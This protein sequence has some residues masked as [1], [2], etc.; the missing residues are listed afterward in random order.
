[1]T[2]LRTIAALLLAGALAA[3]ETAGAT[4]QLAWDQAQVTAIAQE[5][6]KAAENLRSALRNEP[7]PTTG[8]VGGRRS[9]QRFT[10]IVRRFDREAKHLA[11]S[12]ES[13]QGHDETLPVFENLAL[14]VRDG[15]EQARRIFLTDSLSSRIA[16]GRAILD[17]LA[18]YYDAAP[19]PPPLTPETP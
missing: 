12:L 10:D 13:G 7:G 14:L 18:P 1:M 4:A 11:A 17:R 8:S 3:P 16:A 6:P 19:L 5:L 2:S 9:F 15:R